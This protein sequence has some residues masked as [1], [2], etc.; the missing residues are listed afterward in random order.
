MFVACKLPTKTIQR[1]KHL[2]PDLY[3]FVSFC[4]A[5]V[6]QKAEL[7]RTIRCKSCSFC[8]SPLSL[9]VFL[10]WQRATMYCGFQSIE[11]CCHHPLL[12]FI[13]SL[14]FAQTAWYIQI[15]PTLFTT[16]LPS[17]YL[18]KLFSECKEKRSSTRNREHSG[19][20]SWSWEL[21]LIKIWEEFT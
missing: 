7:T 9:V 1:L 6:A 16:L 14:L 4:F 5:V 15:K 20:G 12:P 2:S 18:L 13:Y 19:C 8:Q 11:K 17:T 3:V 10:R 21:R